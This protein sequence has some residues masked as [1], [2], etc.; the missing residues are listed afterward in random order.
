MKNEVDDEPGSLPQKIAQEIKLNYSK[1]RNIVIKQFQNK[2][3][4]IKGN[5]IYK[6][7]KE[8]KKFTYR[9]SGG[10]IISLSLVLFMF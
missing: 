8:D 5:L 1:Y 9:I 2:F 7:I 6:K 3:N 10:V 4:D